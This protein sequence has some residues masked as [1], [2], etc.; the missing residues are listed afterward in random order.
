MTKHAI[1]SF[2]ATDESGETY[3]VKLIQE[4]ETNTSLKGKEVSPGLSHYECNGRLATLQDDGTVLVEG[5]SFDLKKVE[6]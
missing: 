3:T 2:A 4:Y 1:D 5:W 6:D